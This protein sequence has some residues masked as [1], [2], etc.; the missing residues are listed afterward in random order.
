MSPEAVGGSALR[1]CAEEQA[2]LDE[3]TANARA[4][5]AKAE[6]MRE[7]TREAAK[8]TEYIEEVLVDHGKKKEA[9]KKLKEA[10][11]K[12]AAMEERQFEAEARV[13]TLKRQEANFEEKMARLKNQGELKKQAAEASLRREEELAA[14][15]RG[16][17]RRARARRRNPT[18]RRRSDARWRSS[19]RSTRRT[20]RRCSRTSGACASR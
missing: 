17:R 1:R 13:E 8:L 20:S 15:G 12:L 6:G 7:T 14:V 10:K 2:S 11:A 3:E 18:R 5:E 9:S 16:A 19:G 4:L